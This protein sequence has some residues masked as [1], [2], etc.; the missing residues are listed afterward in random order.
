MYGWPS[1]LKHST[2]GEERVFLDSS[3]R[4]RQQTKIVLRSEAVNSVASH[5][6]V[7]ASLFSQYFWWN[8]SFCR[9]RPRALQLPS[10]LLFRIARVQRAGN[11]ARFDG[12]SVD[13]WVGVRIWAGV[14]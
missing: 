5:R 14:S 13:N 6:A 4:A 8:N 2:R 7:E 10:F 11:P 9:D 12:M 3:E 1:A